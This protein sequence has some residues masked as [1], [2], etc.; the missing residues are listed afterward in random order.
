MLL[1]LFVTLIGLTRPLPDCGIVVCSFAKQT[2]TAT[3]IPDETRERILELIRKSE[4]DEAEKLIENKLGEQPLDPQIHLL[5]KSLG[6]ELI[7]N[8]KRDAGER[9]YEKLL[10]Y[11]FEHPQQSQSLFKYLPEI[12]INLPYVQQNLEPEATETLEKA[13]SILRSAVA[14]NPRNVAWSNG[15]STAI[16]LRGRGLLQQSRLPEARALYNNELDR[17]R[18]RWRTNPE[19]PDSWLRLAYFLKA[20]SEPEAQDRQH[21]EFANALRLERMNLLLAGASTFPDALDLVRERFAVRLEQASQFQTVSPQLAVNMLL[22]DK[23]AFNAIA[24]QSRFNKQLLPTRIQ[25]EKNL[26]QIQRMLTRQKLVGNRPPTIENTDWLTKPP[27]SW[28]NLTGSAV[29]LI[30]FSPSNDQGVKQLANIRDALNN[31]HGAVKLIA[32]THE[33]D[34]SFTRL[35]TFRQKPLPDAENQRAL[36]RQKIVA[37]IVQRNQFEFPFGISNDAASIASS[38]GISEIPFALLV[39]ESGI[40]RQ[41]LE[42]PAL[43]DTITDDLNRWL[44]TGSR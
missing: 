9:Q 13:I 33:V 10:W 30:C 26:Q 20:A 19:N 28:S 16:N 35:S 1:P 11:I 37:E 6:N 3:T 23:V 31:R 17:L 41:V 2:T 27:E 36:Y 39:D 44:N 15:L 12:L 7:R 32:L 29:L 25:L 40:C 34:Q 43:V 21:R 22:A 8:R 14:E 42:G 5:R 24:Q 4:W 18:E 38:L